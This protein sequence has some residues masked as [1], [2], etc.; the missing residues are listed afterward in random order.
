M[1]EAKPLPVPLKYVPTR[2]KIVAL[3]YDD[4][5]HPVFT[6][7]LLRILHSRHVRVTFFMVGCRMVRW[8]EI[9]RETL[10]E[11]HVVANHTYTHPADFENLPQSRIYRELG[12]T[13]RIIRELGGHVYPFFRPPKGLVNRRL[14]QIAYA[15]GYRIILWTVSAD[16]HEAN[17]PELMAERVLR[18]VRPG[19]IVLMHDGRFPMRWRD[20]AATPLII[21]ELERRGYRF[22]TVPELL[23]HGRHAGSF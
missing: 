18:G 9:V 12:R 22:V 2:E 4:G 23:E 21:D 10:R 15:K 11:G 16:H 7:E 6:P 17:T 19:A 8:P 1:H 5:P 13:Q 14:A 3:T 20:V